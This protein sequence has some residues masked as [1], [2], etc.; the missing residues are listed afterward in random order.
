MKNSWVLIDTDGYGTSI[1]EEMSQL[2]WCGGDTYAIVFKMNVYGVPRQ[3]ITFLY[4][5]LKAVKEAWKNEQASYD[6]YRET[7]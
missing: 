6:Y 5:G 1:W 7:A 4:N 3:E 2:F